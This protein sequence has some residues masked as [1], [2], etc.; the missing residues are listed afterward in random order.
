MNPKPV[1][2]QNDTDQIVD[3]ALSTLR[4]ATPR[5]GLHGRILASLE[6]RAAKPEPARLHLSTHLAL[7]PALA[8]CVMAV[9]S[10]ILLH[11]RTAPADVA[12]SATPQL[13]ASQQLRVPQVSTL[14]P[15]IDS[16]RSPMEPTVSISRH[17]EQSV[18]ER[19]TPVFESC[20]DHH[21]T[22]CPIHDDN[23]VMGGIIT[24]DPDAQAL[25]DFHA[26]SHPAPPLPLTAQEKLFLRMLRYGN[27][28][29][30]AELNPLVR[31]QHDAEETTAF[32]TFFPD[33][34]PLKQP[35]DDE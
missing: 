12:H 33:P 21:T 16:S 31:A 24:T 29:E 26:P 10:L 14:R 17:P 34:P 27:A 25:A 35:G 22:G 6:H 11:H 1:H 30:L 8:A 23:V 20:A 19:R 3:R 2:L 13:P 9:A 28:T 4:E 32:K 7:W 15:G 18:A 5:A